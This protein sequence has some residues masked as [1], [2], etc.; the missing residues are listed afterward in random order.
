MNESIKKLT[1]HASVRDFKEI[2]LSAETKKTL[3]TAARSASSSHFVQSFS[4]LEITDEALRAQLAEITNSASYV[5]KTGAFYVFIA[6]LYRQSRLLIEQK[7]SLDGL[8]NMESLLVCVVDAAIAAQ[9]MVV[10]AESMELGICYIG[11][12]RN[13]VREVSK[14][15]KLP[16]YTLPL[17]GLTIGVPASKNQIKPR[18]LEKN[19]VGENYYPKE[20]FSDLSEYED[21][22]KKYYA[23][24]E[25]NQQATSWSEKN[26]A[27]F[28][29]VRRPEI[30]GY[31]KEQGF[32][33]N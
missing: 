2:P 17:F 12:I 27:F 13:D 9:S 8:K 21:L 10:A 15:L 18:L 25:S 7:K 14:L 30:A 31:L 32:E 4:I 16:K 29:E 24:R 22:S 23:S 19:Q 6:D 1:E 5:N 26:I 20:Q 28:E 3:I 11:G 33:L